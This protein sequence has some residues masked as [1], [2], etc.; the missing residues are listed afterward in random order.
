MPRR[1][2]I[3]IPGLPLHVVQ[4]GNNK[5]AC[6]FDDDD[7]RFYLHHLSRL[8]KQ[9]ACEVHAFCLMTNHVHLL[10][11]PLKVHSAAKLMRRL[12]LLYTQYANRKY[13]RSGS[14]WEGRF[15]SCVVESDACLLQCY[16]YIESNPLRAGL[17]RQLDD[18]PWSSYAFN[19]LGAE[20]SS[21]LVPHDQYLRLGTDGSER[22][23]NYRALFGC[24]PDVNK[25]REATNGNFPLG[26]DEFVKTL[27]ETL[28][29][30]LQ[31]DVPAGHQRSERSSS[32]A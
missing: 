29:T 7:R 20:A 24:A 21:L 18:Y 19:A 9:C 23:Q 14:L 17:V 4:R 1:A 8:S 13:E 11:T 32:R 10:I 26:T 15:R 16:R 5:Q 3:V 25:I 22:Q 12:D 31:G 30:R 27:G 2:R 28:K 6:F